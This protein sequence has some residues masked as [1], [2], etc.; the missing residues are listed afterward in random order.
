MRAN[1]YDAKIVREVHLK[2]PTGT[3]VPHACAGSTKFAP[4]TVSVLQAI[5]RQS[6]ALSWVPRSKGRLEDLETE[7]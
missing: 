6:R 2:D 3:A 5:F 7:L 4:V 1:V